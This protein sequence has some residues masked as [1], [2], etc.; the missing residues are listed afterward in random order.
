MHVFFMNIMECM[1]LSSSL[2][3][4][5]AYSFPSHIYSSYRS[6]QLYYEYDGYY[7]SSTTIY[8]GSQTVYTLRRLTFG[9]QYNVTI[10]ARMRERRYCYTTLY[11]EYSNTVTITTVETGNSV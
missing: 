2:L 1:C 9:K 8:S 6:Y 10:R 3:S 11:G 7:R 4:F 5:Q